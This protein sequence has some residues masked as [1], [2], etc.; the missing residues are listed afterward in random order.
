MPAFGKSGTLRIFD[1]SESIVWLSRHTEPG[2]AI[3]HLDI[4]GL[5]VVYARAERTTPHGHL[6]SLHRV[7]IALG[8]HLDTA[9]MLIAHVASDALALARRPR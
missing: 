6:E 4:R 2:E 8:D 1:L 5:H 9:V 7:G 3:R